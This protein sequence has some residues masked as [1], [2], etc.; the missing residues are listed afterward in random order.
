VTEIRMTF[1]SSGGRKVGG[2]GR[3]SSDGG[4]DSILR[5]CLE[6]KVEATRSS[7]LHGKEVWHGMGGKYLKC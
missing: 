5:F 6:D 7:W 1:Y 2:P 3:V 4:A